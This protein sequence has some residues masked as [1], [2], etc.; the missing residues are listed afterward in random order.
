MMKRL[1]EAQARRGRPGVLAGVAA[2]TEEASSEVRKATAS[3]E[4]LA[5]DTDT[6]VA[7]VRTIVNNVVALYDMVFAPVIAW[8]NAP[9]NTVQVKPAALPAPGGPSGELCTQ[10]GARESASGLGGEDQSG[11]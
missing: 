3:L 8:L 11:N 5:E 2:A 6:V 4:V 1:N 7:S 9:P 10:I